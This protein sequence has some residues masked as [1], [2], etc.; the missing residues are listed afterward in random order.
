MEII[1]HAPTEGQPEPRY[2]L[3]A[4]GREE[5]KFI[6]IL[7]D[8]MQGEEVKLRFGGAEVVGKNIPGLPNEPCQAIALVVENSDAPDV[9]KKD[10]MDLSNIPAVAVES[11]AE[12]KARIHRAQ[13]GKGQPE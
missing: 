10:V 2:F 8:I 4:Q 5:M 1:Y 11:S 3:Y 13:T 9:P 6:T 7:R 12:R